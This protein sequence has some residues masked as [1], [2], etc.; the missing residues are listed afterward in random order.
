MKRDRF[1]FKI[2][3]LVISSLVFGG[4]HSYASVDDDVHLLR[5]HE[6]KIGEVEIEMAYFLGWQPGEKQDMES[7][8]REAVA[9]LDDIK[10]SLLELSLPEE[11]DGARD[12]YVLIA[13]GLKNIYSGI[14]EKTQELIDKEFEDLDKNASEKHAKVV[15]PVFDSYRQ[16]EKLPESFDIMAEE[17]RFANT[18]EDRNE[19]LSITKLIDS[20]KYKD[21]YDRL[22]KLR[23]QYKGTAFEQCILLRMSDCLI[24]DDSDFGNVLEGEELL[25]EIVNSKQYHPVLFESF[26]KWRSVYQSN[27]HGMSNFSE[28]P[29]DEYNE[30]RWKIVQLVKEYAKQNPDDLWAKKQV[31]ALLETLNIHRGGMFGNS[32]LISYA[33]FY[34]PDISPEN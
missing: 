32:N 18:E 13:D 10:K 20:K 16:S 22:A 15:S 33:Q 27:N 14:E 26:A 7:A 8:V 28:I 19:Y 5:H 3:V 9:K 31:I 6:L 23:A 12:Y 2:L 29:N 11:L 24:M 34:Y 17:A 1:Y 25:S 21:A 30:K 4:I